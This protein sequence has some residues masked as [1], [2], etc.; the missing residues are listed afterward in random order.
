MDNEKVVEINK[1][2]NE[3]PVVVV[4]TKPKLKD[5]AKAFWKKNKV[6]ILMGVGA[7]LAVGGTVAYK[8][9]KDK[10]DEASAQE[11]AERAELAEEWYQRG[12]LEAHSTPDVTMPDSVDVDY[13]PVETVE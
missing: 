11:E 8:A 2:E 5:R 9:I 12:L 13:T 10:N 1:E 6:K 3:T 7:A 4:E